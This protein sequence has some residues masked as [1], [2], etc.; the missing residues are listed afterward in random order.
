MTHHM[1]E[2]RND[3]AGSAPWRL[4]ELSKLCTPSRRPT[5]VIKNRTVAVKTRA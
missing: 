2:L 4:Q 1:S 3:A 5:S